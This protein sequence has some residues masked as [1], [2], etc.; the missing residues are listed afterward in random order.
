MSFR[1]WKWDRLLIRIVNQASS[2]LFSSASH[3]LLRLH[4]CNRAVVWCSHVANLS[5]DK[6]RGGGMDYTGTLMITTL[7]LTSVAMDYQDGLLPPQQVQHLL[8]WMFFL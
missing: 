2:C 8:Y 7:K 6:W 3:I 1:V 4:S 5:G